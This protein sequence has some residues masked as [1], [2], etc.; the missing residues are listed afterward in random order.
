MRLKN[1]IS[2]ANICVKTSQQ[3]GTCDAC[4]QS[5]LDDADSVQNFCD[6]LDSAV[7]LFEH[8]LFQAACLAMQRKV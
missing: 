4:H 2:Q 3:H 1:G 5:D 7:F 8:A 6:D